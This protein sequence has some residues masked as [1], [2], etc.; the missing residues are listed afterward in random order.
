MQLFKF[1]FTIIGSE[2]RRLRKTIFRLSFLPYVSCIESFFFKKCLLHVG[3][4]RQQTADSP[5]TELRASRREYAEKASCS[6][7]WVSADGRVNN[8]IYK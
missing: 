1:N 8:P 4:S 6:R 7:C 2:M 5:D 3:R